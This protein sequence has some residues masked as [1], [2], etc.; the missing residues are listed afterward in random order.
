MHQSER[1]NPSPSSRESVS[2]PQSSSKVKN[3]A[4]RAGL[5]ARLVILCARVPLGGVAGKLSLNRVPQRLIDDRRVFARME[6]TLVND[7]AEIGAVLQ[8]S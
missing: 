2:L 5:Q 6:L 1:P 7:I 8:Q 4:F 3:P